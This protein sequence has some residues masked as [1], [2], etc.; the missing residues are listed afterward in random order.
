MSTF[1]RISNALAGCANK[2]KAKYR[3]GNYVFFGNVALLGIITVFAVGYLVQV[4]SL[5]TKGYQIK[6][7]ERALLT[8]MQEKSELE[9]VVLNMQSMGEIKKRVDGMGMVAVNDVEYLNVSKP[10]AV[11]R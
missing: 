2:Q 7:L 11:A 9:R 6:E 4:N 1:F 10:M 5:A 8:K 3:N